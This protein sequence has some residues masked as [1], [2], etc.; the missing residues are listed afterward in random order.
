MATLKLKNSFQNMILAFLIGV[1]IIVILVME[2]S[3]S[4]RNDSK[5]FL[6][7]NITTLILYENDV[8]SLKMKENP[9]DLLSAVLQ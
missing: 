2:K 8:N 7:L 3:I 5:S 4:M 6:K 9:I 1:R